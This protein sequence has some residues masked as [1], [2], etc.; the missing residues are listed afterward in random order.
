[1]TAEFE[2]VLRWLEW[3]PRIG[4]EGDAPA[5][6]RD[7]PASDPAEEPRPAPVPA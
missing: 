1:M 4:G 7:P 3:L 6:P 2:I 5:T